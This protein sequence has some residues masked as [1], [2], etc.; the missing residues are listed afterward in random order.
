MALFDGL[1]G[2]WAEFFGD[3]IFDDLMF[4]FGWL[5]K[6]GHDACLGFEV[7]ILKS[8]SSYWWLV[9]CWGWLAGRRLDALRGV[10]LSCVMMFLPPPKKRLRGTCAERFEVNLLAAALEYM[11]GDA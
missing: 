6:G 7:G 4:W 8:E 5:G 2:G 3:W 10:W 9:A 1:G 11:T